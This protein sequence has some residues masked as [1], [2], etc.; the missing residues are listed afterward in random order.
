MKI[1]DNSLRSI[2]QLYLQKSI[3]QVKKQDNQFTMPSQSPFANFYDDI[4]ASATPAQQESF[5]R[6]LFTRD[7]SLCASFWAYINPPFRDVEVEQKTVDAEVAKMQ[8]SIKRYR[9][10]ILFDMDPTAD[11]Y[12]TE[13]TELIDKDIIGDFQLQI[14]ASCSTGDL[15]AALHSLRIIEQG[16]NLNW[17]EIEEPAGYYGAEVKDHIGYQFDFFTGC[18]LDHIFSADLIKNAIVQAEAYQSESAGYFDYSED[19]EGVLKI[20]KDRLAGKL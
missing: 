6:Q 9:W 10:D 15:L 8:E 12:S 7:G 4:F 13:L 11:D 2:G 5:L 3:F 16:T 19:W 17:E 20:F 14:E 1:K 18:F